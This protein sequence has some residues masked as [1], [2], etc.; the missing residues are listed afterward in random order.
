[1]WPPSPLACNGFY[2]G[3]TKFI[4]Q[5]AAISRA[6]AKIAEALHHLQLFREPPPTASNWLELGA[7]PGG[8]TAELLNRGYQ[9]TAVDRA[10]LHPRLNN[11][12]NLQSILCDAAEFQPASR[13]T[14]DLILSDMNGAAMDSIR[15]VIRLSKHLRPGGLVIFTLKTPGISTIDEANQMESSIVQAA[16]N[17]GLQHFARTHLTYNRHEFT[18]FFENIPREAL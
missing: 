17:A 5:N 13:A 10:A 8:M 9:V 3:G 15:H 14:Y 11:S 7:S 2:P 16:A 4:R 6:G 12:E 1:L 18:L